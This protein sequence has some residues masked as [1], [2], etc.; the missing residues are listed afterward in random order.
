MTSNFRHTIAVRYGDCD[1]Q[2]VVFNANYLAY[3][4]DAVDSW[5]RTALAVPLQATSDPSN[6]HG[7][8]FDFMVKKVTLTWSK[9]LQFSEVVDLDCAVSRW[10]TS[11]FD[12]DVIGSVV[13]DE[14][15]SACVTYVSVDPTS[16]MPVPV[17]S[18]VKTSLGFTTPS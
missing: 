9:P 8:G 2:R 14:R 13:G 4:D 5:M 10:G 6:L 1:M 17:P 15:F 18:L 12:I 11:S 7:V 16:H 3:V